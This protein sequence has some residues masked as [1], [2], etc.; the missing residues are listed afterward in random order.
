MSE[1]KKGIFCLQMIVKNIPNVSISLYRRDEEKEGDWERRGVRLREGG[2]KREKVFSHEQITSLSLSL[3]HTHTEWERER[4]RE[5]EREE[6][7]GHQRRRA[8]A[9][10]PFFALENPRVVF[11]LVRVTSSR[12]ERASMVSMCR[13]GCGCAVWGRSERERDGRESWET[14]WCSIGCK[15]LHMPKILRDR[16]SVNVKPN[17]EWSASLAEK[18][19]CVW[20]KWF[21]WKLMT[22][23]Y[24]EMK[25]S[26]DVL[27]R[28]GEMT[29][30][31]CMCVCVCVCVCVKPSRKYRHSP[32]LI[33]WR[34]I[35]FIS[36][37]LSLPSVFF[38]SPFSFSTSISLSS[39]SLLRSSLSFA[40]SRFS[41]SSSMRTMCLCCILNFFF[42]KISST[43]LFDNIWMVFSVKNTST[44]KL[45]VSWMALLSSL[46]LRSFT[47]S[48]LSLPRS[49]HARLPLIPF[50]QSRSITIA[51]EKRA[52]GE[53]EREEGEKRER[54]EAVRGLDVILRECVRFSPEKKVLTSLSSYISS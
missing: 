28:K 41:F 21:E 46:L 33:Q 40:L 15:N 19:S 32:R 17:E 25:E 47:L 51:H 30:A 34:Q 36:S 35:F 1:K 18:A 8:P 45:V 11:C 29:C 44:N 2:W 7:R 37:P 24:S 12:C 26:E 6:E 48:L 49:H 31:V 10:S 50:L 14:A 22:S 54:E 43:S 3:T 13:C 4:G 38:S 42:L 5:G 39:S 20:R 9:L 16:N 23:C 52:E 53:R 27:E